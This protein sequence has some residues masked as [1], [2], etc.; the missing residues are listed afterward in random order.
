MRCCDAACGSL[1]AVRRQNGEC[2]QRIDL[3]PQHESRFVVSRDAF[4]E[5]REGDTDKL[6]SV[7]HSQAV[8]VFM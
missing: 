3:R 4:S 6:S 1:R 7:P 2:R 5:A 8:D